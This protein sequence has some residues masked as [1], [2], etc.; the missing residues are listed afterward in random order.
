MRPTRHP[1]TRIARAL[2]LLLMLSACGQTE[3]CDG[4]SEEGPDFPQKDRVHS[5]VQIRISDD[6]ITALEEVL[7]PL[8]AEALPAE[9]LS[10]C[11]PGD[12]GDIIGLVEWG[13]CRD[14]VCGDGSQGCQSTINIA[15][16]DLATQAPDRLTATVQFSELD[17]NLAIQADP[18]VDCA[19]EINGPGF[20]V[21]LPLTLSTPGPTRVLTFDLPQGVEYDL[22]DIEVR[23]LS[24]GGALGF[25][26]TAIDG[27]INLPFL[28]DLIFQGIQAVID[29]V[30]A[31]Q[32]RGF[33]ESFTCMPCMMDFDCPRN[34]GA[35]CVEGLCRLPDNS[36]IPQ[37]L[38]AEGIIDVGEILGGVSPG[39]SAPIQY[40]GVPGSYVDVE[41]GGLSLGV[42]SGAISNRNRCV[43]E[44]PQPEVLEPA[45]TELLRG[46]V[47]PAG[48]S[49][50]VGI[51]VTQEIIGHIMWAMFNGGGLCLS[52]TSDTIEQ[53]SAA[54][55]SIGLPNLLDL[56]RGNNAPVAITMAPQQVPQVQLGTN[57]FVESEDGMRTLEDPLL[58]MTIPELWLDFH[59][60]MEDR[61]TRV[62]SLHADVVLP[63]GLDFTPDNSLIPIIGDLSQ[64]LTNVRA[65]NGEIMEDDPSELAGLLPILVGALGGTISSG[66]DPIALPDILGFRLNLQD[67]GITGIE[68]NTMLAIYAQL[69]VAPPEMEMPEGEM[70]EGEGARGQV[71]TAIEAVTVET[72]STDEFLIDDVDAWKRPVVRLQVDA[73]DGTVDD[74]LMEFSFKVGQSG[75][76]PF[77]RTRSLVVRHPYFLLQ[78]RHQIAV[79]ARRIDDY[80]TLDP[81]PAMATAIIDS[82]AP[83]LGLV[84]EADTLQIQVSDLV[85]PVD[86]LRVEV[87]EAGRDWRTVDALTVNTQGLERVRV[88]VTDEAGNV[89]TD[90]VDLAPAGLIGRPPADQRGGDEDGG[91]GCRATGAE[92]A[93]PWSLLALAMLL[94]FRRRR[95]TLMCLMAGLVIFSIS[96]CEDDA[97]GR[98]DPDVDMG[99]SCTADDQC[100][101][102]AVC[103]EG[104][105]ATITCTDDPSQ[106]ESLDCG[107]AGSTCNDGVCACLPFCPDGCGEGEYC[108]QLRNACETA[109]VDCSGLECEP[110][111]EGGVLAEGEIDAAACQRI[112]SEC[113]CVEKAPLDAADLGR[114]SALAVHDGAAWISGYDSEH[115]DLIVGRAL[116]EGFEWQWV[117]GVPAGAEI[118]AGPSG[119]R[120]G[121]ADEGSDV[122][123]YTSIAIDADGRLHVAYYDVTNRALKY[124][125]SG[126]DQAGP[127]I[128]VTLDA[129]GDAGRWA[130]IAL[131]AEGVPGIAYRVGSVADGEGHVSQVRYLAANDSAP[132]TAEDWAAP[133]VLHSRA[134]AGPDPDTTTYP[135]GTGLFT[136]QARDPQGMPVV[137]WYDRSEGQLWWARM[138]EAG[139]TEPEMLAGWGHPDPDRD[140]DMGANVNL[141][142]DGDG[143]AHL[144]YQDGMTDSLRYLSP[145]LDRD[146]WV[147]DGVWLDVGG[148]GYSVHVVGD[149]CTVRLDADGAP[150][151]VY[152]DATLHAL[153]LR[154]RTQSLEGAEGL[155]W[156]GRRALRGDMPNQPGEAGFYASAVVVG[157]QVWATHYVFDNSGDDPA[158]RLEF[159]VQDL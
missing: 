110:G 13:F 67:G 120:G 22:R 28:G 25:L 155:S 80:R 40:M 127:W 125:R 12:G 130:S 136:S 113:G 148:R 1:K 157:D 61:W 91:C 20:E 152:Q 156:A 134:L 30:L 153:L 9:G 104:V 154:R 63:I 44:R 69:D 52:I 121:V 60:F 142:I 83:E 57:T 143:N 16:V 84:V 81:T 141:W 139:F 146:E 140:G 4:C 133:L 65:I 37:P 70:P 114:Y 66:I 24:Q 123:R 128:I 112:N 6:G 96:G 18:I 147:D 99:M 23:L 32:M 87:R 41:N 15:G 79:R 11:I 73:W 117:D 53:L 39:L 36:C 2:L 90:A 55:L 105:C 59:I 135:E 86:A 72:P 158:Y 10:F 58:T 150:L 68:D 100:E 82:V 46:N 106:C 5:A 78:G 108:C 43:P 35:T 159:V 34:F 103:I 151:I 129:E 132:T 101:G 144:C 21:G 51:G 71:E 33:V 38:G 50:D 49:F 14:E 54:T 27:V 19:I 48:N 85:T 89:T 47:D 102:S 31:T 131:S 74:A 118:V 26:C 119:P 92:Q 109:P 116:A 107:A 17:I 56:A 95:Q 75:W 145:E 126:P 115:G 29:G 137:A 97:K 64:A 7:E 45:R 42:I 3:G 93:S 77:H 138:V 122:G 111:F 149:D 62:F 76:S 88:R 124:A 94:G 8:F 98:A